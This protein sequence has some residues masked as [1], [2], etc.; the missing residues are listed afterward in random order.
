MIMGFLINGTAMC[1][2]KHHQDSGR[3]GLQFPYPRYATN[4][5]H[6]LQL[7]DLYPCIRGTSLLSGPPPHN[8]P[9]CL[10]ISIFF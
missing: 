7:S 10:P 9:G 8:A 2:R 3:C 5:P 4:S 1:D 6:V